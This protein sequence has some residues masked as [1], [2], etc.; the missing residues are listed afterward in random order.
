M[1]LVGE[2]DYSIIICTYNPDAEVF[3]RCLH[4]V[5]ELNDDTLNLEVII[6]DNN[7]TIPIA[8]QEYV[9]RFLKKLPDTK[10]L[11]VKEQGLSHARTAGVDA[12]T[13][14]Y[15][16]FCDDDNI[17]DIRYI[18]VLRDLNK[19][20]PHVGAWG[21]GCVDVD[22]VSGIDQGL[23]S[24]AKAA[25]QDR[26]EKAITYSNQRLW[27]ACYPYGTGLCIQ[28]KY[29]KEYISLQKQNKFTLTDRKGEQLTSGEDT[30][31]VLFCISKGA[32][33][34]VAPDL[35]MT[36]TVPARRATFGYLKRLTYG[37]SVCYS[38]CVSEVFPDYILELKRRKVSKRRFITKT[39]EKYLLLF[40][41]FKP[42]STF[43]LIAYIGAVS[44][45]YMVLKEPV[46]AVVKW[47]LKKLK[48]V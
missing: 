41:K 22:F 35:K 30:Q 11:F 45:D 5:S 12:S 28:K 18:Q 39:L 20:Y 24:Y 38:T 29:L 48:A 26:H 43:A 23:E 46:P 37:T 15:I 10:L 33:A 4:A 3:A 32:A 14:A 21:P 6:V 13:G 2:V 25:F 36:H 16:V 19:R 47:V 44:G 40:F 8:E 17:P 7:S 1:P 31:M 34:G 42:K 9:Q 27:Q